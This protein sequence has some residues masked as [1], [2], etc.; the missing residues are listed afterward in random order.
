[1][2]GHFRARVRLGR[3]PEADEIPTIAPPREDGEP[4]ASQD[5]VYKVYFHGPAYGVLERARRRGEQAVGRFARE[6]PADHVPA[7]LPFRTAPRLLELCFQTAGV[8]EI[9]TTG[10]MGLPHHIERVSFPSSAARTA[11]AGELFCVTRP[12]DDGQR[13][14]A[15]VV[16]DQG[17]VLVRMEGYGTAALPAPVDDGL[18][19]PLQAAM[20]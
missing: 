15:D 2:T 19:A 20:K 13:Y 5:D 1:M 12:K 3:S 7:E 18:R 9:G 16:D 11:D 10:R 8:W 4:A 6:L 14:D 17:R